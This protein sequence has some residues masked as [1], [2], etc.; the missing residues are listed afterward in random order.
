VHG[1]SHFNVDFVAF[2]NIPYQQI[3]MEDRAA[4]WCIVETNFAAKT[5]YNLLTMLRPRP[6][7]PFCRALV[8]SARANLSNRCTLNS[9][10]IPTP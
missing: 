1:R 7:P 10:E 9:A 4:A 8:A 2:L 3:D 6:V 5:L